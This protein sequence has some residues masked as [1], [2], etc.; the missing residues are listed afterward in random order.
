M[1]GLV[2]V[3]YGMANLRSVQKAFESVGVAATI[4]GKPEDLRHADRIVL[5]GVGAF[6]DAI[7]KLRSE[8]LDQPIIE[9]IA[10][11][12]PFLGICLGLQLLFE[13]GFEEG[14]HRG[15]GVLAG[16]VVRFPAMPGL[17]VP[18]MGWNSLRF[19]HACS[20][21]AGLPEAPSV[22]FVHS[23]YPVPRDASVIAAEADYPTPFCAAVHRGNL[24]ATQ[25]HPEKSQ[26]IGL[27]MLANF[28]VM[29]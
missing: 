11:D 16:D 9:H 18:H 26:Q 24:V 27:R 3:D 13:R 23:Y 8:G 28:A 7:A 20:L 5:P 17:K 14:E 10:A 22:Y 4:S 15:L 25:F 19:P 6:R 29:G 21:F 2:I 1:S 12:K